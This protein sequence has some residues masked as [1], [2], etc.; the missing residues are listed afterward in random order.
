MYPI[1]TMACHSTPYV[2]FW[3]FL[4]WY[5]GGTWLSCEP[6]TVSFLGLGSWNK[7]LGHSSKKGKS[8]HSSAVRFLYCLANFSW[9]AHCFAA[10]RAGFFCHLSGLQPSLVINLQMVYFSPTW[11]LLANVV[12][13]AWSSF[14]FYFFWLFSKF[15]E[16]PH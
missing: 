13:A 15:F 9:A 5:A 16:L 10:S 6:Q 12:R 7:Y 14:P 4:T 3:A 2:P 11:P 1:E 8:S